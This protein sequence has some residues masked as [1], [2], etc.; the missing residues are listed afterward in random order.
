MTA[1]IDLVH[2]ILLIRYLRFCQQI[3]D[4][5]IIIQPIYI[6]LKNFSN[7]FTSYI[8]SWLLSSKSG[9]IIGN[10]RND[11]TIVSIGRSATSGT[12]IKNDTAK[13]ISF[14]Q[15]KLSTKKFQGNI[16]CV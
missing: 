8:Y 12:E 10:T 2:V 9:V 5:H 11:S 7:K 15:K 1:I 16:Q 6:T 13:S 3:V 14:D 4:K